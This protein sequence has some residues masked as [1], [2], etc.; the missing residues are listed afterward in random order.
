[1]PAVGSAQVGIEAVTG[2]SV[3]ALVAVAEGEASNI[4]GVAVGRSSNDS[5]VGVAVGRS[6]SIVAVGVGVASEDSDSPSAK[7]G[8]GVGSLSPSVACAVLC[9]GGVMIS[10]ILTSGSAAFKKY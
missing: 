5:G 10:D 3:G 2:S 4:I 1:M 6:G 8:S 9:G 7:N